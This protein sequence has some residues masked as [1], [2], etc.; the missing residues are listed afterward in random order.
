MSPNKINR[1]WHLAHAMPENP[2]RAQRVEWH[3]EHED[4][5]GC[6]P[7]PENLKAE[8]RALKKS[9]AS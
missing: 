8:V 4:S 5:C 1:V 9:R 3:A 2:T 7:V 6:R